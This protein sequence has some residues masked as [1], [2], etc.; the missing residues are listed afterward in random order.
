VSGF[1]ERVFGGNRHTN[2]LSHNINAAAPVKLGG[3]DGSN[4]VP[5][6]IYTGRNPAFS[7]SAGTYN[8]QIT[9]AARLVGCPV[10]YG[11]E[12]AAIQ[13]LLQDEYQII[14]LQSLVNGTHWVLPQGGG[15]L[16][17][18]DSVIG[19]SGLRLDPRSRKLIAV[20]SEEDVEWYDGR[21]F[22]IPRHALKRT[23]YMESHITAKWSGEINGEE[24]QAAN[25]LPIPLRSTPWG[26][27]GEYRPIPAQLNCCGIYTRCGPT[28]IIYW[29][30]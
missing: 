8:R 4:E 11:D 16:H 1:F 27:T 24:T 26:I 30:Q 14:V 29:R 2:I 20:V 19:Q 3:G 13:K 10:I 21:D 7:L 25:G 22:T 28:G 5:E 23:V 9:T 12:Y 18:K 17:I 6:L 15:L